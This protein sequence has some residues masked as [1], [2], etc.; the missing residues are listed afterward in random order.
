MAILKEFG[1]THNLSSSHLNHI[2][3]VNDVKG[4]G[5]K[6]KCDARELKKLASPSI[7]IHSDIH[8]LEIK[9]PIQIIELMKGQLALYKQKIEELASQLNSPIFSIPGIGFTTGLAIL[10]EISMQVQFHL[11][12]IL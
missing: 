8:V 12:Y 2:K 9:N 5:K 6:L 1:S 11:K 3:K 10:S 4:R 7:G